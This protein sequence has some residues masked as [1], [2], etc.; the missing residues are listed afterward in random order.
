[1]QTNQSASKE[2]VAQPK[3]ATPPITTQTHQVPKTQNTSQK[4]KK[5]I[6]KSETTKNQEKSQKNTDTSRD[7]NAKNKNNTQSNASNTIPNNT[8]NKKTKNNTDNKGTRLLCLSSDMPGSFSIQYF[9][10]FRTHTAYISSN[11]TFLDRKA[12]IGP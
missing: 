3:S 8:E 6:K 7:K 9:E 12:S 5:E 10:R 11:I 4:K 2:F 1:M